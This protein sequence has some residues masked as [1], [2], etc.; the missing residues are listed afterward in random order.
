MVFAMF[1]AYALFVGWRD[2]GWRAIGFR[3]PRAVRRAPGRRVRRAG[4]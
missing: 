4:P 3:R 2:A 1:G